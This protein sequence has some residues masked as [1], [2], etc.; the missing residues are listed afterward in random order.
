MEIFA[1]TVRVGGLASHLSGGGGWLGYVPVMSL[2]VLIVICVALACWSV[3]GSDGGADDSDEGGRDGGGWGGGPTPTCP[4]PDA[5]PD[6]WPEFE[7]QFA[8]YV[9]DV[10]A[11]AG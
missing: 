11:R 1:A 8:A 10:R 4:P 7:R 2:F 9:R 5:D 3:R 6:W